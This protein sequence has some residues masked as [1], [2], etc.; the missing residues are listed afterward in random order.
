M[1]DFDGG[2]RMMVEFADVDASDVEVGRDMMM[3]FRIKAVDEMRDFTKYFWK[4]V[5][6]A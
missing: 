1:I 3:M 5:P 2:G 4:A 6:V